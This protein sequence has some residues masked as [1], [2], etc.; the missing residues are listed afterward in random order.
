M[1]HFVKTN[2]YLPTLDKVFDDII[3]DLGK[4]LGVE[5]NQTVPAV[6]VLEGEKSF[7]L[8]LAAPGLNKEDFKIDLKKNKLTISAKLEE[9]EEESKD[10][11]KRKEFSYM[12]FSRIF[13]LPK[14]VDV[15]NIEA[16]Y[17]NGILKITLPKSEVIEPEAKTI[18][19]S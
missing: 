1:R 12:N 17:E 4:T 5:N 11:F 8:E 14:T 19:V 13:E 10:K 7:I 15:Y 18:T 16:A 9:K 3:G 2:P 6:N